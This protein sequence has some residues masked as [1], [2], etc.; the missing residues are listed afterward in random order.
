MLKDYVVLYVNP[1]SPRWLETFLCQAEDSDHAEEQTLNAYPDIS[2]HNVVWIEEG[3]DWEGAQQ[4]YWG[5]YCHQCN[6]LMTM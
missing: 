5:G 1:D 4:R 3:K 6:A 2:E